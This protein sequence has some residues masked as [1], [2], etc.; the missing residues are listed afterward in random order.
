LYSLI[1]ATCLLFSSA[2]PSFDL[3]GAVFVESSVIVLDGR[4]VELKDI[5]AECVFVSLSTSTVIVTITETLPDGSV[6]KRQVPQKEVVRLE[7]RSR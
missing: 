4:Q 6:I 5:P 1:L 7:V 2:A 3:Q